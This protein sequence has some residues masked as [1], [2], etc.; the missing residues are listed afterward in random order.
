MDFELSISTIDSV[1]ALRVSVEGEVDLATAERV[2]LAS[3]V[4]VR[5]G[6]PLI[7]DLSA[8]SFIDSSGLTSV[9]HAHKALRAIGM[10]MTLI[11]DNPRIKDLLSL[12]AIDLSVRVFDDLDQAVAWLGADRAK[13]AVPAQ[14]LAA[15]SSGGPRHPSLGP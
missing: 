12:T 6:C 11:T 9:L 7:L 14:P 10:P 13:G 1:G 5:A 15:P 3:D 8:C 2:T 4:A